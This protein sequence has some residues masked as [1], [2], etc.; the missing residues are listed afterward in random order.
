MR[1]N[2]RPT[3]CFFLFFKISLVRFGFAIWTLRCSRRRGALYINENADRDVGGVCA[4]KR[5]FGSGIILAFVYQIFADEASHRFTEK[6]K[7]N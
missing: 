4:K 7:I 6:E 5:R 2:I 1:K 3:R